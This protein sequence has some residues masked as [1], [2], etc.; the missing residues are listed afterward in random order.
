MAGWRMDV[1]PT[2]RSIAAAT[3]CCS[4]RRGPPF[5]SPPLRPE[6]AAAEE[7]ESPSVHDVVGEALEVVAIAPRGPKGS[8]TALM[9]VRL[10]TCA[11]PR[12]HAPRCSGA[13][14]RRT[15][16]CLAEPIVSADTHD[17]I[18]AAT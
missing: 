12:T 5:G 16:F 6:E 9:A 11:P 15:Q 17:S 8:R 1:S 7:A 10:I 14:R 18:H 13:A 4:G 2:V 3:V